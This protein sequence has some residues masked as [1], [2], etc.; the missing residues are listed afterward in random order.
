LVGS[1]SSVTISGPTVIPIG[2]FTADD[3]GGNFR[4]YFIKVYWNDQVIYDLTDPD[5]CEWVKTTK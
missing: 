3:Y 1:K 5:T 2:S 4:S